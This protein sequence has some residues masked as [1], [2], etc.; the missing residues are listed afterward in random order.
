MQLENLQRKV[1]GADK[2]QVFYIHVLRITTPAV[3]LDIVVAG[4]MIHHELASVEY[5]CGIPN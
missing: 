5:I 2:N 4:R 3:A 1:K